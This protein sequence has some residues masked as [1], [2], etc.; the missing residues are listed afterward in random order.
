M[1]GRP[2]D[3]IEVTDP[4][5]RWI[6]QHAIA[7]AIEHTGHAAEITIAFEGLDERDDRVFCL[8][9]CD[10]VDPGKT[11]EDPLLHRL[12]A[13]ATQD[14][15]AVGVALLKTTDTT[16]R[17][18]AQDVWTHPTIGRGV[19]ALSPGLGAQTLQLLSQEVDEIDDITAHLGITAV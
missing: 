17:L 10:H 19:R 6:A 13:H 1:V 3:R 7:V 14:Q 8:A 4:L 9:V 18:K 16:A 12:G 5:G 11:L 15:D 2:G